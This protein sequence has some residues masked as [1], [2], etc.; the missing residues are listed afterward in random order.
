MMSCLAVTPP[1]KL[2]TLPDKKFKPGS[3]LTLPAELLMGFMEATSNAN[4]FSVTR[5]CAVITGTWPTPNSTGPASAA[6]P[7]L[8]SRKFFARFNPFRT[9][10]GMMTSIL[11]R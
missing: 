3:L 6:I 10:S 1:G 5:D 9:R 2:V 11:R 8:A 7:A 4:G